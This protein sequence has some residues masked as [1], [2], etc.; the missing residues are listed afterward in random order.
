[1][2]ERKVKIKGTWYRIVTIYNGKETKK[3]RK[4][5]EKYIKEEKEE[6]LIIGGDWNA[7]I[8]RRGSGYHEGEYKERKSKDKTLNNEGKELI[9]MVEERDW[10]ILNG[11]KK[12]DEEGEYTYIRRNAA[13]VIDY[14]IVN[15]EGWERIEK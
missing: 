12:G 9:K 5:I 15:L 13:T 2:Q 10:H 14:V 4:E 7:R 3:T 8:G 6:T 11:T 1:M